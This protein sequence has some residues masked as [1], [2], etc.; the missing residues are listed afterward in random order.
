MNYKYSPNLADNFNKSSLFWN[1]TLA[2]S[3][4]KDKATL[5]LKAYDILN[6]NTDARR[7]IN[8]NYTEDR[9][10]TVLKRY[11]MLSFSWKFNT[12]GKKGEVLGSGRGYRISM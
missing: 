7:I 3:F 5:T 10:S 1:A 11:F 8:Q 4:M 9:Q 12:L 6:Q 2:Y